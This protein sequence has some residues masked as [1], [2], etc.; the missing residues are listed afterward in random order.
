MI[1]RVRVEIMG[2]QKCGIVGKSQPVL[3]VWSAERRVVHTVG[4]AQYSLHQD[5]FHQVVK[6][7]VYPANLTAADGALQV[8]PP[9]NATRLTP[10]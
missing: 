10:S 9:P 4:D 3:V 6:L 5:T 7:W 8:P 1:I 2:L